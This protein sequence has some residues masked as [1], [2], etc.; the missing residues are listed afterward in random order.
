MFTWLGPFAFRP[1]YLLYCYLDSASRRYNQNNDKHKWHGLSP[2][3][4]IDMIA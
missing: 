3:S 4:Y 2:A 1:A